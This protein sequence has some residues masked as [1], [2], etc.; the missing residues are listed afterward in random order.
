MGPTVATGR[1]VLVGVRPVDHAYA[2]VYHITQRTDRRTQPEPQLFS[3]G[4]GG[5]GR[6]GGRRGGRVVD[7]CCAGGALAVKKSSEVVP[8]EG[9]G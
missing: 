3:C 5:G 9:E 8:R 4:G 1:I 2:A 7:L 6:G